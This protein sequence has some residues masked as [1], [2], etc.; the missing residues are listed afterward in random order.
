MSDGVWRGVFS[1][2]VTPFTE[3]GGLDLDS[4][5]TQI[6]FCLEAGANGL[7]APVNASE[8]WTLSDEE[9]RTIVGVAAGSAPVG[10]RIRQ[11]RRSDRGGRGDRPAAAPRVAGPLPAIYAYYRALS[12][13]IA[14]PIFI[15]NHDAPYG[16]RMP[17]EFVAR[18]VRELPHVDWV[19]E[20]TCR[21]GTPSR[22]RSR[23]PGRS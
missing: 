8:F 18:L 9:R 15:Q 1:I 11:A 20:E 7:A 5:R 17:A 23:W 16:T 3:T 12:E 13:A 14:I 2:L 6:A 19:K 22:P 4:L 10:R 21:R